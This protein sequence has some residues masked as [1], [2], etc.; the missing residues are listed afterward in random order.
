VEGPFRARPDVPS[1]TRFEIELKP[2][3]SD[4]VTTLDPEETAEVAAAAA[5]ETTAPALEVRSELKIEES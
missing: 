4:P 5:D 3:G 2:E 1:A